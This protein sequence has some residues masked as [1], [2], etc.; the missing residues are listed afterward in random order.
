MKY[1]NYI[2]PYRLWLKNKYQEA[3]SFSEKK[4]LPEGYNANLLLPEYRKQ[5]KILNNK[6]A[7]GIQ[8][9][10]EDAY[11][12]QSFKEVNK[13]FK[14]N[15]GAFVAAGSEAALFLGQD[16]FNAYQAVDSFVYQGM[17]KLSGENL[18]NI[19][20]LSSKVQSYDHNFWEGLTDAGVHKVGGHVGEAYAADSLQE[21]GLDVEWAK[22]SN[23]EGWDLLVNGHEMNVKTVADANTLRQHFNEYPDIPVVIPGDAANIPDNA[24]NIGSDAGI[25]ELNQALLEGKENLVVVDPS[26][27][28]QEIMNQTETATDLL[29]GSSDVFESYIPMITATLSSYREL[30]LLFYGH[31]SIITSFK[32]VGLDI[33]GT[34]GGGVL[35]AKAGASLGSFL[36]PIGTVVGGVVG[37][38]FG[39]IFGR[40]TTDAAKKAAFKNAFDAYSKEYN[41]FNATK[42]L[43]I[44]LTNRSIS[45]FKRKQRASLNEEKVK[46]KQEIDILTQNIMEARQEHYQFTNYEYN[47][48]CDY[49]IAE[50]NTLHTNIKAEQENSTWWS[51]VFF[52]KAEDFALENIN[53]K[54]K[55]FLELLDNNN[56]N[57][58][59]Y[60]NQNSFKLF[61]LFGQL[62][63]VKEQVLNYLMEKELERNKLETEHRDKIDALIGLFAKKRKDTMIS[64]S[65]YITVETTKTHKKI[66]EAS[67]EV[68]IK[69]ELLNIEKRKLGMK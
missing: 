3:I 13:D 55:K 45:S 60:F 66:I 19:A 29:S 68:A 31:T 21:K 40:K 36:S 6:T 43:L 28:G 4:Y 46:V 8:I 48:F 42:N 25:E 23:Q 16:A 10:N 56:N 24:I 18:D 27:S 35:G 65:N 69:M 57:N 17:S 59:N 26:L 63:I 39:A 14:S 53:D 41:M 58:N 62:G 2:L 30:K 15:K 61:S 37:G 7:L 1:L 33:V 50:I 22:E 9:V 38:I 49:A 5:V 34:G 54:I 32:N 64:I 11:L 52:P 67:K 47:L 44:N 51:R 12:K 20:D